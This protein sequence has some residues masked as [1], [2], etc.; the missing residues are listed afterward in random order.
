MTWLG[1]FHSIGVKILRRH[2][3]LV[4]L[5]P[6]FTILDTD[7]QIRLLKQLIEAARHRREALAG[8]PARAPHRQL[9]EPR[10]RARQGAGR[11]S[12]AASPTARALTL[13]AE[14]QER[15]KM[16]NACDFGDLLLE[17]LRLFQDNPDVLQSYQRRFKYMLVDEYQDTNVA[18]YLW[19]QAAGAGPSQHLLR[20]R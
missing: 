5:K 20:R 17:C 12:A 13:Y 18:Q 6:A 11:R 15:L 7:D 1:T 19:L 16:L 8:A 4:G 14:Y 9:E 10:P 3:E 2:A